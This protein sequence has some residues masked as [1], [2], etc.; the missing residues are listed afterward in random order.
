ML[1]TFL[2]KV[3]KTTTLPEAVENNDVQKVRQLLDKGQHPNTPENRYAIIMAC[4]KGNAEILKMLLDSGADVDAIDNFGTGLTALTIAAQQDNFDIVKMLLDRGADV[5]ACGFQRLRTPLMNASWGSSSRTVSLLLD[6]GA[7]VN[8]RDKY[9]YTALMLA[10]SQGRHDIARLLL[11][12]G[13][14]PNAACNEG[15]STLGLAQ[16]MGHQ[17]VVALLVERGA[18]V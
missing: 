7:D 11:D 16:A 5:N 14:D 17:N 12:N 6:R 3:L 8:Q 13:A 1:K 18:R 15:I 9:G 4:V 10:A 2:S